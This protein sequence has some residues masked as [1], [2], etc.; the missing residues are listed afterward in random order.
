MIRL[1]LCCIFK[2]APIKFRTVTAFHLIKKQA[3]D[4]YLSHLI[5]ENLKALQTALAFCSHKKIGC[6][7][8]LSQLCPLYTH[9]D[10][11]YELEDLPNAI[12][13]FSLFASCRELAQQKNLRLTFHP[14]QF[15]I[16]NSPHSHVNANALMD[17][18]YHARLAELLGADVINIH[19]GGIYGN[20]ESA[21]QRLKDA[22]LSLPTSIRQYLTLENDDKSYTPRDL[23][24]LCQE[25][26]VPFVYDVHHHR[27][28]PDQMSEEEVTQLALKTWAREPLFHLSSP[29]NGWQS[30]NPEHHHD[31]I[32]AKDFPTCW[33]NLSLTIEIEAKAKELAL[34]QLM[35]DLEKMK[36]PYGIPL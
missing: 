27:C 13:I 18:H 10:L 16:L 19:A 29:K 28:L 35:Q 33:Q 4:I 20:K 30:S 7:R 26:N 32:N 3:A 23:I 2:E 22:I 24:P 1:G 36:I 5:L 11:G 14:D 17:L 31:L 25:M 8:I 6:F 9:P 12:E 34:A 21:L 15:V